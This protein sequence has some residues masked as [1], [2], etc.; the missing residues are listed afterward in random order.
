MPKVGSLRYGH[1]VTKELLFV[2]DVHYTA[3][4]KLFQI[5]MP[6][7]VAEGL[8]KP[9]VTGKTQD[10]VEQTAALTLHDFYT[11]D[12]LVEKVILYRI[13]YK[14]P[15]TVFNPQHIHGE[16]IAKDA[17]F[18]P[19]HSLGIEYVV[20]Y[21]ISMG[22]QVSWCRHE[23]DPGKPTQYRL[24]TRTPDSFSSDHYLKW[25]PETE[26]FFKN[27]V[28]ALDKMIGKVIAFFGNDPGELLNNIETSKGSFLLSN[29]EK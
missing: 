27:M 12:V 13:S 11:R 5:N 2:L 24:S 16:P 10:E 25:T 14:V 19:L 28:T 18:S 6:P 20:W 9:F 22:E 7:T 17:H 8:N 15:A 3:K 21:R 26:T 4:T 29:N 23:Y 1:P